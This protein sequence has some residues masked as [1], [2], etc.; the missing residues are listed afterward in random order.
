MNEVKIRIAANNNQVQ[1]NLILEMV[2]QNRINKLLT[3]V[4]V[5]FGKGAT[6]EPQENQRKV[7]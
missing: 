3:I 5:Y 6:R 2:L 1:S 4:A 7:G